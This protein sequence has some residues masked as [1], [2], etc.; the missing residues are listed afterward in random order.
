MTADEH[1]QILNHA[2]SQLDRTLGGPEPAHVAVDGR[3]VAQLIAFGAQYGALISFYDLE[4]RPAGNW[5]S[6]FSHD[7]AVPEALHA[8][9][10]L[11]EIER[12][13]H[14]LH[15]DARTAAD[16]VSG[17]R[18]FQRLL[19]AL[20]RLLGILDR[21]FLVPGQETIAA[22]AGRS[23]VDSVSDPL[24][25]LLDHLDGDGTEDRL[26]RGFEH[27]ET[28][29]EAL[30]ECLEDLIACLIDE[31][32]AGMEDARARLDQLLHSD[33]HAPQAAVYNAFVLLFA[34]ARRVL[35]RFPNRLVRF[36]YGD[37]LEQRVLPAVPDQ[38]YLAFTRASGAAQASVALGTQ[39][40][41]GT[42]P[43]GQAIN[44]AA[45]TALEVTAAA[46]QEI[47]IHRITYWSAH[48][49][50]M[51]SAVLNGTV[52]LGPQQ[53]DALTPFPMFGLT[54]AGSQD[55]LTMEMAQIGFG[56]GSPLLLLAGGTRTVEVELIL[57]SRRRATAAEQSFAAEGGSGVDALAQ[58]IQL[59]MEIDY[60]TAGG[61][62]PVDGFTVDASPGHKFGQSVFT[63]TFTL[64]PDAPPVQPVDAKASPGAPP[65]P[66][67]ADAFPSQPGQPIIVAK[68][69]LDQAERPYAYALLSMIEIEEIRLHV[70]V[71]ALGT[72]A[73]S[74]PS[75]SVDPSQN[76]AVFGVAPAKGSSLDISAP[77]LFR[78]PMDSLS[79]RIAWAG[80][81]VTSGGFA[82]YYRNYVI[83]A[84]GELA[85]TPLFDNTS[86]RV[87]TEVLDPGYWDCA[88]DAQS[89]LFQTTASSPPPTATAT[90]IPT[91]PSTS[92]GP[93]PDPEGTVAPT[94]VLH[95][96]GVSP[97]S[98]SPYYNPDSSALRLSLA[99]PSYAFGTI[100]YPNNLMYAAQ[101]A[102]P[103]P[104]RSGRFSLFGDTGPPTPSPPALPNPPWMPM[105]S[106]VTIDYSA[107]LRRRLPDLSAGPPGSSGAPGDPLLEF[108][109]LGPF[110]TF[111]P[112]S[113]GEH[114]DAVDLLPN[115]GAE[116]A[117]YIQLSAPAS[118]VTLLFILS[119][120]PDGWW[121]E[122]P[123]MR[124]QECV[125]HGW[126]DCTLLSDS[127][128]GLKNS[129]IVT[130]ALS[131][132]P[133]AV[134]GPLLRV[135][136]IGKT[137]N[138]PIV[139]SV[140]AN[141]LKASWCG[142]GGAAQ[143]GVPLPASTVT[144]SATPLPG[145]ASISQPMQSFGGEPPAEGRDFDMW[146][147]ER[148]RH[149]NYAI[150][151]WDY[152][153]LALQ[154]APSLWQV[155]VIPAVDEKTGHRTPGKVWVVAVA[156][157]TTP[158]VSDKTVPQA[159]LSMLSS[160]GELLAARGSPFIEIAVTNPPYRRLSVRAE[161]EFTD[162]DTGAYW[163]DRLDAEL[164][165]WLSP[166]PDPSIGARPADYYSSRAIAE[167][168][169]SRPYVRGILDLHV[170]A[171][172]G[173]SSPLHRYPYFTS[174]LHHELTPAS[175]E[176]DRPCRQP[177]R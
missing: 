96:P 49:G 29:I 161:L 110:G 61:W 64:P 63:I 12:T 51:P 114:A 104:S 109:H 45:D 36:Y 65:P 20:A 100:L 166:W 9:L 44:Y 60:S 131:T 171:E 80:L 27:G 54:E 168:I 17:R 2:T 33:G 1:V 31:L 69:D 101:K 73:L 149:K 40:P 41:A 125:G 174:A 142:P 151:L 139:Q 141:A 3:T 103:K 129:G 118:E 50:P 133:D 117:L 76:F 145:I 143:L 126:Q 74:N 121:S 127:T 92:A 11:T 22:F 25:R 19:T 111:Q 83:D 163:A 173:G 176:H 79:V 30:N 52:D 39:F 13:I 138:A 35:N 70:Q 175:P 93:A 170:I 154:A 85:T 67:P 15:V 164:I 102:V 94:T 28:W 169:R 34:E 105:A 160:L 177:D 48:T 99:Q 56:V 7:P 112:P 147:A 8:A 59:N 4:N 165:L 124:W 46:V 123:K 162:S 120:G 68:L 81:P 128:G 148:L 84:D 10:D 57:A 95:V 37:V 158:N 159:D 119:A 115:P 87:A 108:W 5:Q 47:R 167:F 88:P 14:G 146:M 153:R 75:G 66:L 24:A 90:P 157:P 122:P 150:D 77:E 140:T 6:F 23:R 134:D 130:L 86:F 18:L 135:C 144:K 107:S 55:A 116:A 97:T 16:S 42:D 132:P 26:L 78:K 43:Q 21:A 113:L 32:R 137:D 172:P 106:S 156:G 58:A 38:L 62:V 53:R 155:A 136:P 98:P 152:A 89:S 91:P 72:L 82:G 71:E